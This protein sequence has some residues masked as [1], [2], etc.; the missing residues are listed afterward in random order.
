[1]RFYVRKRRQAPAVI[2]VALIDILIVLLIFLLVTTTFR[3]QPALKLALPESSHA[4]RT[5]AQETP[6]L[7]VSIDALGDLR[8]GPEGKPVTAERLK[9]DLLAAAEKTQDLKL[10]ISADRRAPFGQIVMVMDAAKEAKIKIV[11][12]FTKEAGKP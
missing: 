11:N 8:L 12:A 9:T 7:V 3:Q 5:G 10:A 1:M 6:P 4:E 2:I